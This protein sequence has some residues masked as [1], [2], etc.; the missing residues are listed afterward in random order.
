MAIPSWRQELPQ[1]LT[2]AK[3]WGTGINPVHS[4]P[5]GN[6]DIGRNLAPGDYDSSPLEKTAGLV[7]YDYGYSDEDDVIGER[8]MDFAY[9]E[10]HPNLGDTRQ[11]GSADGFPSWGPGGDPIP[12]GTGIRAEKVGMSWKEGQ[13]YIQKPRNSATEGW[14]NKE[15]GAVMDARVSDESQIY[16][17]TSMMQRDAIRNNNSAQ[18]RGTDDPRENIGTRLTG[19]KI[20]NYSTGIRVEDMR[21]KTQDGPHR[22]WLTR[23]AGTGPKSWD[24]VNELYR[25]EPIARTI[26]ADVYQGPTEDMVGQVS[27]DEIYEDY[28]YGW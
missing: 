10:A 14:T 20:K 9:M 21:P 8:Q 4:L 11:R 25:S 13:A 17:T 5:Y 24:T 6:A 19:V 27:G 3:K 22:P 23:S 7:A 28:S 12:Q 16:V 2:G 1:S 18:F 26:P 15:H